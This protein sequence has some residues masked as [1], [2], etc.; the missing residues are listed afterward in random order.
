MPTPSCFMFPH[1][2]K[3]NESSN[4]DKA[5]MTFIL[6][7][8]YEDLWQHPSHYYVLAKNKVGSS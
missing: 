1:R 7:V 5:L 6:F 8:Y 3:C 4:Q 2:L